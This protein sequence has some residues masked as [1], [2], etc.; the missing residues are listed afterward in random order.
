[1]PK[2]NRSWDNHAILPSRRHSASNKAQPGIPGRT[3]V[4]MTLA[5]KVKNSKGD[6]IQS[7]QYNRQPSIDSIK[8]DVCLRQRAKPRKVRKIGDHGI[9][10]PNQ[11][12]QII[13][14]GWARPLPYRSPCQPFSVNRF[15]CSPTKKYSRKPGVR[16]SAS[17]YQGTL[18]ASI[19]KVPLIQ[20]MSFQTLAHSCRIRVH[21][22]NGMPAKMSVI[23]PF[24]RS[25]MDKPMKNR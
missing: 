13:P 4:Q 1:M 19:N 22:P 7:K 17:K 2:A 25:P 15:Q 9:A 20:G 18:M 12:S 21:N 3:Y 8:P 5:E 14:S 6:S 16:C 23:G 10:A 11:Y 24:A